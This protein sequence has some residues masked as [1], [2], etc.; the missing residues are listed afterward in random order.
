MRQTVDQMV[1]HIMALPEK[2]RIV[3]HLFYYEDYNEETKGFYVC[4]QTEF[5]DLIDTCFNDKN[6]LKIL[7]CIVL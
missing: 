4:G 5:S 1:D 3:L 6:I 2:Y 7:I